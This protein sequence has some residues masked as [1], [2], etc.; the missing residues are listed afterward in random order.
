MATAMVPKIYDSALADLDLGIATEEAHAMTRRLAREEG[1]LVGISSGAALAGALR[2]AE[3]IPAAER[4]DAVIVTV[5]PD[6]GDKY[7]S[8]RFWEE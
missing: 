5:F 3:R 1:L 8:Q 2:I 6:A 7:L 4:E